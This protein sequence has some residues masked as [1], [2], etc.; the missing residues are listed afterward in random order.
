MDM[1]KGVSDISMGEFATGVSISTNEASVSGVYT[2][3]MAWMRS[4]INLE[5]AT[6]DPNKIN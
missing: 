6:A 3:E 4:K 2:S 5:P 1:Y